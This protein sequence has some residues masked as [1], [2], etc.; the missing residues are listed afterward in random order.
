ERRDRR[1]ELADVVQVEVR[2]VDLARPA[3]REDA[4]VGEGRLAAEP[5]EDLGD[6]RP[7]LRRARGPAGHAYLPARDEGRGEEGARVRQV[8][9]DDD[10]ARAH[11]PGGD[12]PDVGARVVDL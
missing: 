2:T 10:V 4:V 12:A 8:G 3:H 11:G 9:L 1:G 7:G 6:L 5:R